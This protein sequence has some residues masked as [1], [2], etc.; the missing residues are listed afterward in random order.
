MAKYSL[1]N[2]S[3]TNIVVINATTRPSQEVE[4]EFERDQR[5]QELHPKKD[6]EKNTLK[7]GNKK[8]G[9][10]IILDTRF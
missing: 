2:E 5:C 4:L 9:T 3:T 7:S 8:T 1:K 10:Q 6:L